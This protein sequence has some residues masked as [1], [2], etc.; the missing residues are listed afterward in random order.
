MFKNFFD[1][2]ITFKFLI[3][4]L[5]I[6]AVPLLIFGIVSL[7]R[8]NQVL[9]EESDKFNLGIVQ[10][11]KLYLQ[12]VM[13]DVEDLIA[14]LSGIEDI[15][16][17][18]SKD[19]LGESSSYQMLS[20]QAKLG[21]ILNGY[22]NL[23]GLVSI[24]VF[25][26]NNVHYYVGE[27]LDSSRI[28]IS[29]K[30]K[31]C[32]EAL[33]SKNNVYWSG[34]EENINPNS[35]HKYV[36]NAV[37]LMY[38]NGQDAS[39]EKPIGV[40]IVSYD[41]NV[42]KDYFKNIQYYDGYYIIID[43]NKYIV[44]HPKEEFVGKKL[45]D[46]L[47]TKFDGE[48]GQFIDEINNEKQIVIY[49]KTNKV[50]LYIA[51]IIPLKNI[52]N[53]NTYITIVLIAL[54]LLFLG[55]I[56]IYAIIVSKSIVSPI[57]KITNAFKAFQENNSS[58]YEKVV[59]S[60]KDEIG[61]L[62]KLLNSFIDAKED[63]SVQKVLE[64]KL[65]ERN[66]ELQTTLEKLKQTQGQLIQQEKLAGIG[67][68]A[69]GVAH[70]INNPLGFVSSNF[71]TLEEYI[72]IYDEIIK[73]YLKLD[74]L[75]PQINDDELRTNIEE[76]IEKRKKEK[77]EYLQEDINDIIKDTKEGIDR[78][79]KIVISMKIFSR[80]DKL[81]QL[82][83]Y[84]L[85][86]GIKNTL[87]VANNEIKYH[88]DVEMFLGEIPKLVAIGGQINQ[89]LLNLVLNAAHAIKE[90]HIT[91]KG[92]IK[93]NTYCD[94]EYI[95]CEVEDNGNGI[96]NEIKDK[97]F[98]PFFTTKPVGQ[99]T[100]LGLSIVYDIIVNKHKGIINVESFEGKGTKFIIKLLFDDI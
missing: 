89:V 2:S 86:E 39:N 71:E 65:N 34:I 14:N 36:I 1:K 78:I 95:V 29:V 75:F 88:A 69:A 38:K 10:E 26:N 68:L 32:T 64:R 81:D 54:L 70:E 76:A 16:E 23:K 50:G 80:V 40:L 13:E 21:Y 28:N 79:S 100:G 57:K 17:A 51:S 46:R 25:S 59:I 44:Y 33:Q 91:E 5:I 99:G 93:I 62:G 87:V 42:F 67:Q 24:D 7:N 15:K 47:L 84:D 60:N 30:D 12:H 66:Q 56:Y 63:I 55:M 22:I 83:E 48:S 37:K 98:E 72:G 82:S 18:L 96:P 31:L 92:L 4:M 45:S 74:K 41:I 19:V 6:G 73:I 52:Y 49:E 77:F 9:K 94:N 35:K 27:T 8:A 3:Y 53:K 58:S 90:N 20:T 85:N 97:I 43:A 11:K 61:E